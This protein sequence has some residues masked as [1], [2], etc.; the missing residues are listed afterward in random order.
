[1]VSVA[2]LSPPNACCYCTPV[3]DSSGTGFSLFICFG[4]WDLVPGAGIEPALR[5]RGIEGEGGFLS[6]QSGS[7]KDRGYGSGPMTFPGLTPPSIGGVHLEVELFQARDDQ[8][9]LKNTHFR[10]TPSHVQQICMTRNR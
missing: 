10:P 8:V 9:E 7:H 6:R 2:K 5:V 1:M 4:P 3:P